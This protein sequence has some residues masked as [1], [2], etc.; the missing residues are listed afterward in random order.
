MNNKIL[1]NTKNQSGDNFTNVDGKQ[2]IKKQINILKYR[3]E[4]FIL[5]V[6]ASLVANFIWENLIRFFNL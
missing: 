6:I 2:T 1:Y 4:G 5:G 3:S